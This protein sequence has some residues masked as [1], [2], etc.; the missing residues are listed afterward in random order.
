MDRLSIHFALSC[1]LL[2]LSM[3]SPAQHCLSIPEPLTNPYKEV[4]VNTEL[5]H[6]YKSL[7]KTWV[8]FSDRGANFNTMYYVVDETPTAVHVFEAKEQKRNRLINPVDAGWIPKNNLLVHLCAALRPG[9]IFQRQ[10]ITIHSCDGPD[11]QPA[12]PGKVPLYKSPHDTTIFGH[13][14]VFGSF[15]IYK[16]EHGRYLLGSDYKLDPDNVKGQL[17]GW[18]DQNHVTETSGRLFFEPN[19][20]VQAVR[21]R[22]CDTNKLCKVFK[23]KNDL[24]L[25]QQGVA[26]I[27]PVW[28]ESLRNYLSR[29]NE[30]SDS[31]MVQSLIQ[32]L[33]LF[34][35]RHGYFTQHKVLLGST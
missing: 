29:V 12:S 21:E 15:F 17:L 27:K 10:C 22:M 13:L 18:V 33:F 6:Q 4:D 16:S 32:R 11:G 3:A 24:L 1:L 8:V 25:D 2:V 23:D 34:L 14:L 35:I 30:G 9:N 26:N 7:K 31:M 28:I 19:Y 5:N 20:E